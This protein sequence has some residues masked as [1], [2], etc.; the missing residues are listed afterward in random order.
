MDDGW[1]DGVWILVDLS[2]RA[3]GGEGKAEGSGEE[4]GL[5]GIGTGTGAR[6]GRGWGEAWWCLL[7]S[8]HLDVPLDMCHPYRHL[9]SRSS[10]SRNSFH[11]DHSSRFFGKAAPPNV[12][13]S[14][15][16]TVE[17]TIQ[18]NRAGA[19]RRGHQYVECL[20]YYGSHV[21]PL[22]FA[23]YLYG[24]RGSGLDKTSN[25][26]HPIPPSLVDIVTL[27][28][29]VKQAGRGRLLCAVCCVRSCRASYPFGWNDGTMDQPSSIKVNDVNRLLRLTVQSIIVSLVSFVS[30]GGDCG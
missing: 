11:S 17:T 12:V 29:L 4:R 3:Y 23:A 18:R 26:I 22:V 25:G 24:T 15:V 16:P 14:S 1:I 19:V 10:L 9:S 6:R 5:C 8:S 28:I 7:S 21:S 13:D 27:V 2:S 20:L 30:M